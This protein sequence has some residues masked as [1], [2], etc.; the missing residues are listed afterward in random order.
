MSFLSWSKPETGWETRARLEKPER[1]ECFLID[2]QLA[3]KS[4]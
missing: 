2:Q 4:L 1:M 3:V